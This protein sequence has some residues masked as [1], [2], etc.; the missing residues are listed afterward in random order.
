MT[1]IS[2]HIKDQKDYELAYSELIKFIG[3]LSNKRI[4]PSIDVPASGTRREDLLRGILA[5]DQIGFH[6][7]E[8]ARHFLTTCHR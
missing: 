3:K 5:A 1:N 8:Y 6:L 2:K 7:Y 4:Y